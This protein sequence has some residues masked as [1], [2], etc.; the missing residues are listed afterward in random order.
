MKIFQT[1]VCVFTRFHVHWVQYIEMQFWVSY[2]FLDDL[3]PPNYFGFGAEFGRYNSR[4]HLS[5]CPLFI[6]GA[7]LRMKT[8]I[9]SVNRLELKK[10]INEH[11]NDYR[12]NGYTIVELHWKIDL[13][14][15]SGIGIWIDEKFS[16]EY[17]CSYLQYLAELPSFSGNGQRYWNIRFY[18]SR[19]EGNEYQAL[20]ESN[21]TQKRRSP[22][23]LHN[24]NQYSEM[25]YAWKSSLTDT[26][27]HLHCI[28]SSSISMASNDF[29]EILLFWIPPLLS[30]QLGPR[31][32][33]ES[34]TGNSTTLGIFISI[35][36]ST[37]SRF[38][39]KTSKWRMLRRNPQRALKS[40]YNAW[41]IIKDMCA[42]RR[43]WD[44]ILVPGTSRLGPKFSGFNWNLEKGNQTSRKGLFHL[45][46]SFY[47]TWKR[48]F[49][50]GECL[51]T[52]VNEPS[53]A[54]QLRYFMKESIVEIGFVEI[55]T[56]WPDVPLILSSDRRNR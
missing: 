27:Y 32:S 41:N 37:A 25:A 20:I 2:V 11:G 39:T 56:N 23:I 45:S 35:N 46:P 10:R 24:Y 19:F 50:N 33:V 4:I 54:A 38:A 12:K 15:P 8:F 42:K 17:Y 6:L 21:Y 29:A 13:S 48:V 36:G 22:N 5:H 3:R 43:D 47:A 55:P 51:V 53:I 16:L 31:I 26:H 14:T 7:I 34:I 30:S 28:H 52:K 9:C 49:R 1:H 18:F 40:S 44:S